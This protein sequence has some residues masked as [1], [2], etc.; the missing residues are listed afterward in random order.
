MSPSWKGCGP[1]RCSLNLGRP[2]VPP[3]VDEDL[4]MSIYKFPLWRS[5][6]NPTRNHEVADLISGLTQ[7][8]Q[9]PALP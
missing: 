9:D 6:T 1:L 8:V 4:E 3:A 5:E 2:L 7:W